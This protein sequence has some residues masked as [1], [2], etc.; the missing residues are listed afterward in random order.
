[1][2]WLVTKCQD[3]CN[4]RWLVF[5]VVFIFYFMLPFFGLLISDKCRAW[6]LFIVFSLYLIH[7]LGTTKK[8]T[9]YNLATRFISNISMELYLNHMLF[10]RILEK[11]KITHVLKHYVLSY[12][13]A[14]LS[15]FLQQ[16]SS[17]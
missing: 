9:I 17:Q 1:M 13:L 12:L 3:F 8:R 7:D 2:F 10:Y 6:F 4:W 16:F 14:V 5:R 11:V 15:A